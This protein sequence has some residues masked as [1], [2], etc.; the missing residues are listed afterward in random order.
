M[1]KLFNDMAEDYDRLYYYDD[2]HI[3]ESTAID[4]ILKTHKPLKINKILD[5]GCGTGLHAQELFKREYCVTGLDISKQMLKIAKKR[6]SKY[7]GRLIN[8]DI[9]RWKPEIETNDAVLSLFMTMSYILDADKLISAFKNIYTTL[10]KNG[11]FLFDVVNCLWAYRNFEPVYV[12]DLPNGIMVWNRELIESKNILIAKGT[13]FIS[14]KRTNDIQYFRLFTG[15]ELELLLKSIGF[16]KV[17]YY[18]NWNLAKY[19]HKLPNLHIIAFK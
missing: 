3:N 7:K 16:R 10:R 19:S 13:F 9:S 18:C 14:G 15:P 2:S 6:V 11:L 1:D 8:A 4:G 17:K 5:V 12:A